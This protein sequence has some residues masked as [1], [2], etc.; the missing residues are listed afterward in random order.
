M[1]GLRRPINTRLRFAILE[2]DGFRCRYCGARAPDVELEV[3]HIVSVNDGGTNDETNLTAACFRCNRGKKA[4]SQP[5]FARLAELWEQLSRLRVDRQ[6]TR[7][8]PVTHA[9][10]G[11]LWELDAVGEALHL[12]YDVGTLDEWL[13]KALDLV[14]GDLRGEAD[15][16]S[17][18]GLG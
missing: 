11:V 16:W 2:R 4:Q 18:E 5:K 15:R 1:A 9:V 10:V 8:L 3:D 12:S 6:S 7:Q 13:A 14:V 17:A